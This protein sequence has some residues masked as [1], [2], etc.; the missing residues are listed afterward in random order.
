MIGT[1]GVGLGL[2]VSAVLHS[3][4]RVSQSMVLIIIPQ[5]LLS[6]LIEPTRSVL[7]AVSDV[8]PLSYAVDAMHHL[9]RQ[10]GI[11]TG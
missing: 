2:M 3:D 8:L 1:L 6:W 10:S 4:L 11:G 9:A 5:V 7:H